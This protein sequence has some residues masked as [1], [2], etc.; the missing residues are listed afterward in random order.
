MHGGKLIFQGNREVAPSLPSTFSN[1]KIEVEVKNEA[2]RWQRQHFDEFYA[3]HGLEPNSII[4]ETRQFLYLEGLAMTI[5]L[6]HG[7]IASS[8]DPAVA[9][10]HDMDFED[11]GQF[12]FEVFSDENEAI[13]GFFTPTSDEE[14]GVLLDAEWDALIFKDD[15]GGTSL[16]VEE[17]GTEIEIGFGDLNEQGTHDLLL[18]VLRRVD[19]E[20]GQAAYERL[21]TA[22]I[23]IPKARDTSK[24]HLEVKGKSFRMQ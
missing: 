5:N 3:H 22:R 9:T 16:K 23:A 14:K 20:D 2:G 17:L 19:D 10:I 7:R 11:E 15:G 12:Y 4:S 8:K 1:V 6:S 13:Y 18:M 24:A 21:G